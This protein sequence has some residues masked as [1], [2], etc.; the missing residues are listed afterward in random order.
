LAAVALTACVGAPAPSAD[1]WFGL[2]APAGLKDPVLSP[3]ASVPKAVLPAGDTVDFDLEGARIRP[4]VAKVVGFAETMRKEGYPLWGRISGFPSE[5]RTAD[6]V[7]GELKAAGVKD[8]RVQTYASSGEFWW[9]DSWEVKLIADP[10]YGAATKDIVLASAIPVSRSVIG[11]GALTAPVIYAGDAG[12]VSTDGVKGKIAIQHLKPTMGAVFDRT[13]V[14][15]SSKALIKAGAV[16]VITWIESA[17]N[18]RTYDFG[19]CGGP[20]FNL[21]GDDGRF[22]KDAIDKANAAG[23]P[24]LKMSMSLKAGAKTGLSASNVIGTIPGASEEI[25]VVNAHLDSWFDGAGDNADGVGVFLALA[26]HFAKPENKPARTLVFVGS[27]GHHSPGLNG[28]GAIVTA[29]AGLM[30]KAVLV[31]NLEHIAQHEI[32]TAPWMLKP[33]EWSKRFGVSNMSPWLVSTV[34]ELSA[35]YG[36]LINADVTNAIP[37]DLG[38]YA[39]LNVAR[40]QAI[41]SGPLYHTSG[42][43]LPSI[44]D[45][46]LTKAAR[47]YAAFIKAAGRAGAKEIN[48]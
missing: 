7:A 36:F 12:N 25:I 28:P 18:M 47:F 34:K 16:G 24:G 37:G 8:A 1:S 46:G 23:A 15:D 22:L 21:G 41:Q 39:P 42:D 9:P 17:G 13:M 20:C 4:D 11:G 10:A 27:G 38:G 6:W 32:G 5:A 3:P 44:S 14:T 48:P 2:S 31:I 30:K 19:Q 43:L 29:N 33:Q 26:R 45:E 40:I 35:R